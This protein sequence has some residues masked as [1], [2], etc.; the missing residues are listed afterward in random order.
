MD[1]TFNLAN[2]TSQAHI[3]AVCDDLLTATTN[4]EGEAVSIV[5]QDGGLGS[6]EIN[7]FMH[8]FRDWLE[9]DDQPAAYVFPTV[10]HNR[11]AVACDV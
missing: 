5:R 10:L 2:P 11:S 8:G 6:R 7:C 3:A 1:P 4:L 9:R